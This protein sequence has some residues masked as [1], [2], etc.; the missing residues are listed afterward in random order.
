MKLYFFR[1]AS[2]SDVAPSDAERKLTK[3]GKEEA[4]IA[5]AALA[6]LGVKPPASCPVRFCGRGRPPRFA[7]KHWGSPA[8]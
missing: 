4:R 8:N 3:E 5:G 6:E 1:H 2:A 7:A